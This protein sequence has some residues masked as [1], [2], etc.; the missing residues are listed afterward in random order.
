M[1]KVAPFQYKRSLRRRANWSVW[2]LRL[3]LRL[4]LRLDVSE[5]NANFFCLPKRTDS[6]IGGELAAGK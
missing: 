2:E 1:F 4:R 3:R 5:F 6:S